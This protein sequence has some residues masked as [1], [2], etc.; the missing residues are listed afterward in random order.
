MIRPSRKGG[1]GETNEIPTIELKNDEVVPLGK[2]K[3]KS[4]GRGGKVKNDKTKS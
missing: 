4:N 1:V 2:G 3:N